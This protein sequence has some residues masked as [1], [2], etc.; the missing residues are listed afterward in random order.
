M[1]TTWVV[2]EEPEREILSKYIPPEALA[3]LAEACSFVGAHYHHLRKNPIRYAEE[4]AH[5]LRI[6]DSARQLVEC[7][8]DPSRDWWTLRA[9]VEVGSGAKSGSARTDELCSLLTSLADGCERHAGKLPRQMVRHTLEYEVRWIA[10]V[11]EPFG[12]KASAAPKSKFTK[13]VRVCFDAMG[14]Y[15]DPGRAIRSYIVH[16]DDD[17]LRW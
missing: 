11:I 17:P 10:R 1:H 7:F 2:F 4:R 6:T 13:I 3:E 8:Q 9:I 12:I 15:S 5:F 14:I 16:R